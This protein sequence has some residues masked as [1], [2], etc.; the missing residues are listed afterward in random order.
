ME[1][2]KVLIIGSGVA[3]LTSAIYLSRY[4]FETKVLTGYGYGSLSETPLVENFPGFPDGISGLQL[5]ENMENQAIKFGTEIIHTSAEKIDF[6]RSVVLDDSGD[7]FSYDYLVIATG[8]TP[9]RLEIEGTKECK[10]NIHYCATCDGRM[11]KDKRV[12]VIGGGDTAIT[13]ALYLSEIAKSVTMIVR[14]NVWRGTPKLVE[15]IEK[16]SN[17]NLQMGSTV[18]KLIKNENE[19]CIKLNE[20]DEEII[21]D[22]IFVSI[23]STPNSSLFYSEYVKHG[24]DPLDPMKINFN[25]VW[26]CGDCLYN[27]YRQAIVSAGEGA[28]V[29]IDIFKESQ[30]K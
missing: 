7:E 13:E 23:G 4:N 12:V 22:G 20:K 29:A 18:K 17:I 24:L 9:K 6:K 27:K 16:T 26:V 3:G 30:E 10:N 1:K 11:Y 8:S 14:R 15:K 21:T 28:K 19:I 2:K 25:N 5:L